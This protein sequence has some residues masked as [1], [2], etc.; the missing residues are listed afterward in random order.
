MQDCI[1]CKILKGEII[2]KII[3]EN[4]FAIAILDIQPASDGHMLI[5]PKKH[6]RNFSLT[7]P[8]YLDGMMRLAKNMT[9]VLE[10]VFP[11]VLGFNYL[12]NSNS[13]AGQVIMH[14][15]LHIIP[16]Q[17]NERGFVFK[18]IKEEGDISNVDEIY[19]K[20]ITKTQKLKKSR[21]SKYYMV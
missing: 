6:Y 8:I 11:N 15:H 4:E 16:K 17:S 3:D 12:I 20:I 1:F 19:K 5:I 10:E 14:T 21:L 7:D 13:S 18:A 2:S 9:F